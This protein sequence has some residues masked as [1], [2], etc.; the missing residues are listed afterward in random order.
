MIT[1]EGQMLNPSSKQGQSGNVKDLFQS[2]GQS[3]ND[4]S[5]NEYM[6]VGR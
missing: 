5:L 4:S 1:G 2:P 3:Q 6:D